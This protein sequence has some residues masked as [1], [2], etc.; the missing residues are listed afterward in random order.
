MTDTNLIFYSGP[1]RTGK[2]TLAKL[3]A[4]ENGF[5]FIETDIQS[6]L[7]QT[8]SSY[9]KFA[10]KFLK[11]DGSVNY[12]AL[13]KDC[14]PADNLAIHYTLFDHLHNLIDPCVKDKNNSYIFDRHYIDVIAYS[15]LYA[16]FYY[17]GQYKDDL[18]EAEPI[19]EKKLI[20]H[21][22]DLG[23]YLVHNDYLNFN[24]IVHH[25]EIDLSK[26]AEQ[27]THPDP[28]KVGDI[29]SDHEVIDILQE[30]FKT[31]NVF[32]TEYNK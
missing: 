13:L 11:D 18:V 23:D 28:S 7:K 4:S 20:N 25:T 1:S 16:S 22:L 24:A 17:A 27:P 10:N 8:L 12:N 30:A 6:V 29:Y 21:L 5:I 14:E 3:E 31:A 2:S 9:K 32:L 26:L 15:L 19:I